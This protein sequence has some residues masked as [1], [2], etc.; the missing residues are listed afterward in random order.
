MKVVAAILASLLL[1]SCSTRQVVSTD[2]EAAEFAYQQRAA[3][4]SALNSWDMAGKLSV[5]DGDDGGSGKLS[6]K[7]REDSSL[8]N[9]RGALGRGAWQLD[10]RPGF[11]ELQKSDGTVTR[12]TTVNDLLESEIGWHIPVNS[13]KWWALGVSAPG[14]TELLDLDSSGRVLAMQQHGW[15]ISFERYRQFDGIEL[16]GR[17]DAVRGRY[18]VKMAVSNWTLFSQAP[19][20][21][22]QGDD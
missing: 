7:V 11:A 21:S 8:M 20:T 19:N 13:L 12:S 3:S 22:S 5:D 4:L 10:S 2:R 6:W 15:N 1:A 17:M 16:P 14:D 9:F 18:R